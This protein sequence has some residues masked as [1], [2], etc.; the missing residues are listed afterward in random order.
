MSELVVVA[1]GGNAL[2]RRGQ[3]ADAATQ[4][5]NVSTAVSAVR[6]SPA[7]TTWSS[8]GN[9]PQVGLLALQSEAYPEVAPY[10]STSSAQRARG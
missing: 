9:G 8:P 2:L 5:R 1:L 4:R 6:R 7:A 10:R 3:A